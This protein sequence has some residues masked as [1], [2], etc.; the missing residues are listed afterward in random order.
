[1]RAKPVLVGCITER[2]A[3]LLREKAACLGVNLGSV[4]I[5]P[6]FVYVLV[7]APPTVSPHRIAC[8]LKA[9][10]SG[11]L[12]R[13]FRELTTIPSLWTRDYLVATGEEI[14]IDD[15]FEAYQAGLA[16]R[17]LPGRPCRGGD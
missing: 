1:M 11:V 3:S 15:L 8:G 5:Q 16:P 4:S 10:S 17:R 6:A 7:Q 14:S 2:L 13:E 9:Y 12:R